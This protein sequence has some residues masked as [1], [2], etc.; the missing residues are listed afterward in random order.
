[1]QISGAFQSYPGQEVA[2]NVIFPTAV[3]APSLGRPL[4]NNAANTT[5]NVI[6]PGTEWADRVNQLDLRFGK[7]LRFGRTR[8]ALNVDLYNALNTDAILTQSN[9]YSAW[10]RPLLLLPARFFK[11][12]MTMD[13]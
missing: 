7:I 5:V 4:S 3:V 6:T 9:E 2:A 1:M 12:S 10:Q 11:F 13:F 8:T